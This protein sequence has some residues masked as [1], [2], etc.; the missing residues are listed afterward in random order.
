VAREDAIEVEGAVVEA[1]PRALY[2]VE[3]ANG[4]RV[5][6]HWKGRARRN[7]VT[8]P[9]GARVKLQMSPF[10]LSTGGIIWNEKQT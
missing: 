6:A 4:H 7:P 9:L 3:L 8:L 10:D 1:L 5:L 2:R